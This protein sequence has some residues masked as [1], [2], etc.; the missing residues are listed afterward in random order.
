MYILWSYRIQDYGY[1]YVN[2]DDCYAE[3]TRDT[4]GNIVASTSSVRLKY[5]V[6]YAHMLIGT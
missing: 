1:N 2:V 6:T 4:N 5:S 3:K